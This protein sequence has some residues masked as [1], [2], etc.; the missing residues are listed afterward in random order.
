MGKEIERKL[1]CCSSYQMVARDKPKMK[2]LKWISELTWERM[3]IKYVGLYVGKYV[4]AMLD[5][6]TKW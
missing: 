1:N 6:Y 5:S 4:L 3:C 2:R